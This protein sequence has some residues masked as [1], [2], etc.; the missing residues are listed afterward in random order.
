[1]NNKVKNIGIKNR[2]YYLFDDIININNFDS[3]NIKIDEKSNKHIIIY[4][5]RYVAIKYSKC[6]RINGVNPLYLI[7]SKIN[8]YFED[9]HTNKYLELVPT[10]ESTEKIKKYE[11]LWSKIRNL[12]A[13]ITENSDHY[14]KE[15][16][17]I[18]FNSDEKLSINKTTEITS[19]IIVVRAIFLKNSKYFRHVV[20]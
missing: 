18:K 11:E 9:I 8:G 17:K 3:N 19:M 5:I 1:M 2:T 20:V 16:L 12:I 14:D 15:Y 13:S 7:F 10:N 6:V 4:Y